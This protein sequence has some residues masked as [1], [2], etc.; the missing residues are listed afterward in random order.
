M[1]REGAA[2]IGTVFVQ[3]SPEA[4]RKQWRS[5]ADQFREKMPKLAACMDEAENDVLAFVTFP[6]SHRAQIYSTRLG[7]L[8]WHAEHAN[9]S[10]SESATYNTAWDITS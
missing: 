5:V 2:A 7:C 4:A 3:D 9:L 1:P 8:Q 10:L 6:H